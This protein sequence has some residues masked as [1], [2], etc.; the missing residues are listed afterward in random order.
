MLS[1]G[2]TTA[3]LAR[4]FLSRVLGRLRERKG[5]RAPR[6][7][8]PTGRAEGPPPIFIIGCHRSGTSLL[9]RILD[10]HSRIACPP[11]SK[12]VLPAV[13]VLRD[14]QS[15]AALDSMGFG[16]AEV[17]AS[18]AGF[19]RGFFDGYAEAR[20]KA[21]WADKTPN[22]VD[23]LPELWEMFGPEARFLL[24]YRHGLDVA[25]SLADP[26]REFRAVRESMD[27]WGGTPPV[28]AGRY[29]TNQMEKIEAFRGDHPDAS[30]V[31]RYEELTSDPTAVLRPMFEWLGEPWEPAVMEYGRFPHDA[32]FEDPDVRRRKRIVSNSGKYRSWPPDVQREVRE[33]CEPL[34][35][36]LGY[37]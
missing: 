18:L 24:I 19:V 34:L 5:R 4:S 28:A 6:L 1:P 17:V 31:I 30:R 25:H 13:Q 21:R 10:S 12:F 11:E 33:V 20:G 7:G 22:Y 3:P 14:D 29:W 36:R 26:H 23:C 16:R 15:M 2:G 32:G 27:R 9:R 37:G 8:P 35:S